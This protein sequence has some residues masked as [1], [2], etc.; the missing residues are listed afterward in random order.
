MSI[1]DEIKTPPSVKLASAG[2]VKMPIVLQTAVDTSHRD[3]HSKP[4]STYEQ[5]Q[6]SSLSVSDISVT[7][8]EYSLDPVQ[9]P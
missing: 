9:M 8:T 3:A 2:E 6:N 7:A 5:A 4:Y 1:I